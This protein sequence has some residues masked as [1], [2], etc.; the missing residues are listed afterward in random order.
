MNPIN[1]PVNDPKLNELLQE[2]Q[3]PNAPESVDQRVSKIGRNRWSF[4]LTG[5]IRVPV[6]VGLAIAVILLAMAVALVRPRTVS[7]KV[8]TSAPSVSLADFRP[9][10]DVHVRVIH[11]HEA[12]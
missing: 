6:P 4:L 11:S 3:V 7:P 9:V 8:T 10:G 12:N 5:S 2:W 1:D